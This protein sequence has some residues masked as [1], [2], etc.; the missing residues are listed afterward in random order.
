MKPP[1]SEMQISDLRE[2]SDVICTGI[3]HSE[4]NKLLSSKAGQDA[5]VSSPTTILTSGYTQVV[6][7]SLTADQKDIAYRNEKEN[8]N[9]LLEKKSQKDGSIDSDVNVKEAETPAKT[10][11]RFSVIS[12]QDE[13][14]LSSVHSLR[15]S[16][17]PDVYLDHQPSSPD[18]K[19]PLC[20]LQT[21]S[22]FD[23]LYGKDSSDSGD[24]SLLG[25]QDASPLSSQSSRP[26]NDNIKKTSCILQKSV[27]SSSQGLNSP[28]GSKIPTINITSFHSQ[29][30]YVSSDN[31][32][33]F[34]DADM[35]KEL[36][37]LR[38]K[39]MKEIAELQ[40][41]HKKEIET[42]YLRLGKPLPPNVG[43]LHSAPPSGRRRRTSKHK[44]KTG[45]LLNPVIQQLKTSSTS[46]ISE[47]KDPLVKGSTRALTDSTEATGLTVSTSAILESS[48]QTQQP[49]SVKASLSSDICS[50]VASE[51]GDVRGNSGQ[52]HELTPLGQGSSANSLV[53]YPDPLPQTTIQVQVQ[54]N[55]SNNK[56]GTFTDDLHKLVDQW[57]SKTVGAVQ[58]K[59]SLNQ[60][61]QN[62]KRQD[63]EPKA[64]PMQTQNETCGVSGT[65]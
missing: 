8:V 59:P 58:T 18:T 13:L 35:K 52:A 64:N 62:Q 31:D 19:S 10:I 11:G 44:L 40:S 3:Q 30:S 12:T 63:M 42:L 33:E 46:N 17:P 43:F 49:C 14:T 51:G 54:A 24:E 2:K 39:H 7:S 9:V 37:N 34:E 65:P 50:G 41:Q 27:K 6:S 48:V 26:G 60:L 36:Q 47:H 20:R 56:K 55:N 23:V 29:S 28:N 5:N 61:K 57:T 45:K 25:K 16:A 1:N 38:E 53:A 22:S 15:Y 4:I 21:A 32:S